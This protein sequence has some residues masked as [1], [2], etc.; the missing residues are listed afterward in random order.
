VTQLDTRYEP[1]VPRTAGYMYEGRA[2][3]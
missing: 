1:G 3:A 2:H